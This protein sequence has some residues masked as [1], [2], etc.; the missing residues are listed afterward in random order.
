MDKTSGFSAW[1]H[2]SAAYP[3]TGSRFL[4]FFCWEWKK[5][6]RRLSG[7]MLVEVLRGLIRAAVISVVMFTWSTAGLRQCKGWCEIQIFSYSWKW[8]NKGEFCFIPTGTLKLLGTTVI[9]DL[10]A[11]LEL[12]C[13]LAAMVCAQYSS[14]PCNLDMYLGTEEALVQCMSAGSQ[15][16]ELSR[17]LHWCSSSCFPK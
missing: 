12:S 2:T 3:A 5:A 7:H 6:N 8:P 15:A 13:S 17:V 10:Q 9:T 4:L 11:V 16:A 14:V 1:C